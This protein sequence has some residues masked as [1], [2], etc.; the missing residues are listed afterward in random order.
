MSPWDDVVEPDEVEGGPRTLDR[1]GSGPAVA[2]YDPI[3]N[4][5]FFDSGNDNGSPLAPTRSRASVGS[6]KKTGKQGGLKG[7]MK[8][9]SRY[10]SSGAEETV[11]TGDRFDR[12]AAA[13][14]NHQDEYQDE[15]ERELN[16]GSATRTGNNG[17]P[18]RFDSFEPEGPED[19][20]SSSRP[21]NGAPPVAP[22]T[23]NPDGDRELM[24]ALQ[25]GLA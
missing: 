24:N 8:H 25:I 9:R 11:G 15:F 17:G 13:R 21:S 2:A 23:N 19:A 12:M 4:E 5:Q 7:L 14:G 6:R 16:S 10:E 1:N 20:W 3:A 18:A 22:R